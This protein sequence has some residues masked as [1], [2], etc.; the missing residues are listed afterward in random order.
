MP[1]SSENANHAGVFLPTNKALV[2]SKEVRSHTSNHNLKKNGME[3]LGEETATNI[4]IWLDWPMEVEHWSAEIAKTI[5]SV[6][7]THQ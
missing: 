3:F 2:M 7:L 1:P 6:F 5:N 4:S